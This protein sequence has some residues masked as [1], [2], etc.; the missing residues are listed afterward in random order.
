[1]SFDP[2]RGSRDAADRC[3]E[4][5]RRLHCVGVDPGAAASD[6]QSDGRSD[7]QP[8]SS[9]ESAYD[10]V[11]VSNRL[12]VDRLLDDDGNVTYRRS[13]GGLVTAVEPVM[14]RNGGGWVGRGGGG[15]RPP[16]GPRGGRG[17]P[18]PGRPGGG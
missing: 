14:Q 8:H 17:G 9:P 3:A 5:P 1:M 18:P 12:P 13:P 10:L 4:P 11:V 6:S 7:A 16:G 2:R 15:D